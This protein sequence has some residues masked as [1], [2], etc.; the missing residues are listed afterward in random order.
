MSIHALGIDGG[1]WLATHSRATHRGSWV[2]DPAHWDGLSDGHT[3]GTVVETTA[4]TRPTRPDQLE[5]LASLLTRRHA[6]LSVAV[7]PLTDYAHLASAAGADP[8][9]AR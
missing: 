7:R 2:I 3:R 5:P 9:E 1:G 6:D 8:Q 4:P